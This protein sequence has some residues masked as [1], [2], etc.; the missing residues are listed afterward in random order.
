VE[1][2]RKRRAWVSTQ[3][4]LA[5]EKVRGITRLAIRH[6]K[7]CPPLLCELCQEKKWQM[8]HHDNYKRPLQVRWL[9]H[10]CHR[11]IHENLLR[12]RLGQAPIPYA[13]W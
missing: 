1:G 9:C 6:G 11:R 7:L 8:V 4:T 13:Y 3:E 10:Q 5:K 12:V 2:P